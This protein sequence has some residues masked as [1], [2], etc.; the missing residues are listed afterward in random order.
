[1]NERSRSRFIFRRLTVAAVL[2][3]LAAGQSGCSLFVMAGKMMFGDPMRTS[4]FTNASRMDLIADGK[5][6][7][8]VCSTPESIKSTL[9]SLEFDMLDQIA[10]QL[11][12]RS[13]QVIR[14]D[15]VATWMDSH[16]GYS[17][18]PEKVADNFDVDV[19]IHVELLQFSFMEENS[20]TLFR[21]RAKGN[22]RAYEVVKDSDGSKRVQEIYASEYRSVYPQFAPLST[23]Q[24]S[25]KTFSKRY[26][27]Q[28]STQI[29]QLFYSHRASEEIE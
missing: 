9:P 12:S 19:I 15:D 6:V 24:M 22:I 21:G 10:R 16:G 1:M 27:D 20:P 2:A 7:I 13:M 14:P 11:R 8:V 18:D 26:I 4:A 23:Q 17:N 25:E 28:V 29:A 3:A 5:K